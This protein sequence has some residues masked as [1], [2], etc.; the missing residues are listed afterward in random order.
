MSNVGWICPRCGK[1]WA[2]DVK[3]CDCLTATIPLP[4]D[5]FVPINPSVPYNPWNPD[6]YY[7]P[8]QPYRWDGSDPYRI[9][10]TFVEPNS[11]H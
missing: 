7:Q 10:W 6:P 5:P 9:T 8:C 2:P 4:K 1:V 11:V 3:S